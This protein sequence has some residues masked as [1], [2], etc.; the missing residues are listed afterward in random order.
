MTKMVISQLSGKI[1]HTHFVRI[2]SQTCVV[3]FLFVSSKTNKQGNKWKIKQEFLF[4]VLKADIILKKNL[5]YMIR[6]G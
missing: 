2:V 5:I 6:H 1:S 4:Y 3:F